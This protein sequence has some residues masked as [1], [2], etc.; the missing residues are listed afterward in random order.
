MSTREAATALAGRG[1]SVFPGRPGDKRPAVDRWEQRAI[2]DPGRV[3][4][5]WPSDRHNVGVACGPS[6]LVVI[7]LDPPDGEPN[8]AALC[9]DRGLAVP[10]TFTVGTPRGGRHL[11][12]TA[13][14]GRAIRNSAG[15]LA[16]HIDVRGAGGYVLAPGSIVGGREY[17]VISGRPV[18]AAARLARRAALPGAST[19]GLGRR[20]V[21]AG[22]AEA[23][24]R[25]AAR[26]HQRSARGATRGAEQHAPLGSVPLRRADRRR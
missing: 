19:A 21:R 16:P 2:S 14:P 1:W 24:G 7:D 22:R 23:D 10:E 17:R 25:T 8:F 12:F 11:Y 3:S 5:Y 13:P 6:V 26:P 18:A 20:G 15:K 4:R 9:L